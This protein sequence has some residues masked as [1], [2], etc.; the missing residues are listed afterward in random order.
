MGY[1]RKL[2]RIMA[3]SKYTP[4]LLGRTSAR[5]CGHQRH[6]Q[7]HSI[8]GTGLRL[9]EGSSLRQ[10]DSL[11]SV[12]RGYLGVS[13]FESGNR[14]A[15]I[16]GGPLK[17]PI[18]IDVAGLKPIAG[19]CEGLTWTLQMCCSAQCGFLSKMTQDKCFFFLATFAASK[20]SML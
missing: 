16:L 7:V 6:R 19:H 5:S 12:G 17:T 9:K 10:F 4:G 11:H 3:P 15:A 8:D 2:P 14:N 1:P 13:F 18:C 20:P